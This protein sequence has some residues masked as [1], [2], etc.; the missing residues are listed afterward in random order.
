MTDQ[1][2]DN[3]QVHTQ[4]ESLSGKRVIINGGTTG[5]GRAA[6]LLLASY[7]ARLLIFGRH[8]PE[9]R[10]TL[11]AIKGNGGEAH[12]VTADQSSLDDVKRVFKQAEEKLGGVDILLNNAAEAAAKLADTPDE[13]WRYVVQAN[14]M[15]Y[16]A[17]AREAIL[18]MRKSGG[19]HI[20]NVGSMSADLREPQ[21]IYVTTKAAI[22]AFSESLRK[23]VNEDGIKVSLVEP[24]L[25][26]TDLVGLEKS[27][28]KEKERKQEI[29]KPEDVA[30]AIHYC[31]T[32]PKRMD[33]VVV[34]L[35]PH[36]QKI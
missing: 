24:G 23:E 2:K 13:E 32:Q 21:S 30:V 4:V 36:M 27:E 19:G 28:A 14:I 22:Q 5:I 31:L 20:V 3:P 1:N 35:R 9:L 25:T 10:N 16:M 33:V 12:G 34:Q 7:G 18:R 29:M 26:A 8:E 17:C 6:A 15:G 11:E